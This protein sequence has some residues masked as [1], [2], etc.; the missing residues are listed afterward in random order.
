MWFSE[1]T[2]KELLNTSTSKKTVHTISSKLFKHC[3]LNDIKKSLIS[4]VWSSISEESPIKYSIV[5]FIANHWK[6]N[7]VRCVVPPVMSLYYIS[8]SL[9]VKCARKNKLQL[10]AKVSFAL[11]NLPLVHQC[12][13]TFYKL[14][15]EVGKQCHP[16]LLEVRMKEGCAVEKMRFNFLRLFIFIS[17]AITKSISS[18]KL[19]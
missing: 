19:G 6:I 9:K 8:P 2:I 5:A 12:N 14:H 15:M 1:N 10:F 16:S 18:I 13:Q 11:I 3:I 4:I 17:T 7:F